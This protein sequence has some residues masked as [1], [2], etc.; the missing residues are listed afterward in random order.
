M[1]KKDKRDL[2]KLPRHIIP[3]GKHWWINTK[4]GS[5][6]PDHKITEYLPIQ[7]PDHEMIMSK[8]YDL[9]ANN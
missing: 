2:S 6:I 9:R 1:T 4:T 3:D 8:R 5:R 7:A